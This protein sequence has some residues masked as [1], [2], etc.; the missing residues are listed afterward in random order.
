MRI[1]ITGPKVLVP[2]ILFALLSPGLLVDYGILLHAI[3]FV[4]SFWFVINFGFKFTLTKSDLI[5][6]G[7]LF[8]LLTPGM[9]LTLPPVGSKIFFSGRTGIGPV[10]VHTFVFA[11]VWAVIRYMVRSFF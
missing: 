3:V 5:I 2:S 1:D 4:L 11:L 9:V 8:I 6:T 7:L 10:V